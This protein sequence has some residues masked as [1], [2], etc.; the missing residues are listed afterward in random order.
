MAKDNEVAHFWVPAHSEVAGNE[1]ANDL[2]KE[3]A[4]GSL[5][6]ELEDVPD[7]VRWQTS[8]LHPARRSSERRTREAGQ[9]AAAHVRPERRYRPPSGSSLRRRALRGARKSLAGRYNYQLL[10][11]HAPIGSFLHERMT[12]LLCR[13]SS[14]RR[15]CDS[16]RRESRHHLFTE[17]RA[18]IPQIGQ[19][20]RRVARDVEWRHPRAPATRKLWRESATGAVL[21]FLADAQVGHWSSAPRAGEGAGEGE[22]SGGEE[23]GPGPP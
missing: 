15:W 9:W 5:R 17:C 23:G 19:L 21:E 12:G 3:A 20:W 14:Q 10:S 1:F 22:A 11:G 8:I 16:G 7:G 18:W 2:A 4:E 13:G 6:Y